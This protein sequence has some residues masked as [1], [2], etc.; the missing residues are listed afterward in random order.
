VKVFIAGATGVLGRRL[1]KQFRERGAEVVGLARNSQNETI[2]R[3]C[4]GQSRSGDI[5]HV[6]SLARA[7][8]GANVIVHAATAIPT[9]KKPQ[10]KEWQT[11]DQI[12]REGTR[13]LAECAARTGAKKLLVQ[14]ITWVARP[15][16]QSAFD[17]DSPFHT[18]PVSQSAAEMETIARESGE[19]Q[20]LDVTV[21][22]CGWFYAADAA[23]TRYFGETLASRKLPIIGKGD[24]VWSWI[25][26]DDAASAFVAAA[27]GNK[28][29]VWHIVDNQPVL[30]ADYLRYFAAH[31][32]APAPRHVPA[33]LARLLAGSAAVDFMTSSTRTSNER[34]RR[35]FGWAPRFPS[36]KEGLA[37][38]I[39]CWRAENFLG[40]QSKAA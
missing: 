3:A 26:V 32:G 2:I 17:E 5:F 18:D 30:S 12:R 29:G 15:A 20:G 7:A 14:S 10:P 4:G 37:E 13:A 8:E 38:V 34:F 40:L 39:S 19:R 11:N 21:L 16:D 23:H 9:G 33:W 1:I 35:D 22:R 31:L 24:A 36:Y 25:H 6:D 27:N 28:S